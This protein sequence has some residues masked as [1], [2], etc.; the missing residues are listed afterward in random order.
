MWGP[1]TG[2][3]RRLLGHPGRQAQSEHHRGVG[4]VDSEERVPT[5][6][7]AGS[8]LS[9]TSGRLAA[10]LRGRNN[11][12]EDGGLDRLSRCCAAS[13]RGDSRATRMAAR[14][15]S[16]VSSAYRRHSQ[17]SEGTVGAERRGIG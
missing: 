9:G 12:R 4:T 13:R 2:V 6:G 8:G 10:P 5:A 3:Q 11:R 15:P 1:T 17:R 14:G 7:V 16:L